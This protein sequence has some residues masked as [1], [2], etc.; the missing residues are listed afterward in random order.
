MGK[1]RTV[2]QVLQKLRA[3]GF[4]KS[5]NHGKGTSHQRYIHRDDPKRYADVS[6]H[7]SG[8]VLAKGTLKSIER[9]SGVEF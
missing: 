7:S 2:R 5:P 4:V 8:D 6:S 1:Q 9:T 3:E